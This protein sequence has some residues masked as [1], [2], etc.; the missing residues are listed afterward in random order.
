MTQRQVDA[1]LLTVCVRIHQRVVISTGES[2][3]RYAEAHSYLEIVFKATHQ[4]CMK[5][6]VPLSYHQ[7][8]R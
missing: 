5:P 1:G 6:Q 7:Y 4:A 8:G 2:W 3:C